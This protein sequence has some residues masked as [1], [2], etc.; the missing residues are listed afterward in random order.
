MG[1]TTPPSFT[2][3]DIVGASQLNVFRDDVRWAN[4]SSTANGRPSTFAYRSSNQSI[5]HATST[6]VTF[7]QHEDNAGAHST[8]VNPS[9]FTAPVAGRYLLKAQLRYAANAAGHRQVNVVA[10]GS[11]VPVTGQ[12]GLAFGIYDMD[13]YCEGV[14]RMAAGDFLEVYALQT[15]GGALNVLGHSVSYGGAFAYFD[16]IST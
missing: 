11:G 5:N 12:G 1:Y 4:E 13:L 15:S 14:V 7:D 16:W 2:T 6:P 10:N 8:S 9:R 3:G